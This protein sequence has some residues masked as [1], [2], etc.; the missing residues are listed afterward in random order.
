[1]QEV[2]ITIALAVGTALM[3]TLMKGIS[4]TNLPGKAHGL[5]R[6]DALFWTDWTVAA[7]VALS[8]SVIAAAVQNKVVPWKQPLA[9][10]IVFLLSCSVL[11]FCLR[12]FAYEKHA[13]LRK[14]G[15]K[16]LG[17]I[18]VCNSIG[19]LILLGAVFAGVNVYEFK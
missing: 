2:A 3:Q 18:F 6:D 5:T 15:Y 4:R 19:I 17:W 8:G 9:M 11:P 1:M 16:G 14:W 7:M 12:V 10:A 13:R